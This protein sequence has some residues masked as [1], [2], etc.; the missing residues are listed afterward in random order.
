MEH[1][2]RVAAYAMLQELH[3]DRCI[4]AKILHGK[5]SECCSEITNHLSLLAATR[6]AEANVKPREEAE[7]GFCGG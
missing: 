7:V 3:L 2:A 4:L 5:T 6:W 1:A